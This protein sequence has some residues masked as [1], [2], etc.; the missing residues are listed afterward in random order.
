MGLFNRQKPK[1]KLTS[2]SEINNE[3]VVDDFSVREK[4]TCTDPYLQHA[5]VSVCIDILTRNI[6]RAN[7]EIRKDGKPID[8]KLYLN[9]KEL[10]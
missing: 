9:K 3:S 8:P 6:A 5:W 1:K 7:F 4:N 10:I 2:F